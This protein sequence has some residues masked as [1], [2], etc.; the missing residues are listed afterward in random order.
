[1]M[2]PS[3]RSVDPEQSGPNEW[4]AEE[5]YRRIDLPGTICYRQGQP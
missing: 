3:L 1:M 2:L 5:Y 4:V